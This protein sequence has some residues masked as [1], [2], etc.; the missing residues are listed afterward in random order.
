MRSRSRFQTSSGKDG[1]PIWRAAERDRLVQQRRAGQRAQ[2]EAGAVRAGADVELGAQVGPGFAERVLVHRRIAPAR[3]GRPSRSCRRSRLARPACAGGSRRPPASKSTCTS[4][5]GNACGRDEIDLGAVRQRPVLDRDGGVGVRRQ[6]GR[7]APASRRTQ[8]PSVG[9]WKHGMQPSFSAG[10]PAARR[11]DGDSCPAATAAGWRPS[12]GRRRNTSRRPPAPARR[13]TACSRAMIR[14]AGVE[15]QAL[16]P[17]CCRVHAPAPS[18]SRACR[19][20]WPP[21]AS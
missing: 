21:T 12:A 3:R 4:T 14:G 9:I 18:R 13:V 17:S 2:R 10:R 8:A 16:R 6:E 20:R 11:A 5:I 19:F 7:A 15:R 1:S